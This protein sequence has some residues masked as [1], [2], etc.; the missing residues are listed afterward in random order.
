MDTQFMIH[1]ETYAEKAKRV[2]E[3]AQ[4]RWRVQRFTAPEGCTFR[5]TV[6]A[7]PSAVHPLL[8]SAGIPVQAG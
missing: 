8:R 7:P 4:I 6:S 5:F 3:R 2:L 1:S